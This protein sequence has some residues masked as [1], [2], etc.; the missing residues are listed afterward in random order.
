FDKAFEVYSDVVTNPSF[1]D[2]E[3]AAMKKRVIAQIQSEDA[4]WLQQASRYFKQ[5]YFGPMHSPYQFLPIGTEANVSRFTTDQMREW[6][7]DKVLASRRVL[8][9]YGDVDPDKA[10]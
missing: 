9:I 2:D 8:A 4:D 6:Y 7:A 5:Q 1:P 10:K 3:T